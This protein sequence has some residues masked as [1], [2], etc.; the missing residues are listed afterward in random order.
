MVTLDPAWEERI[1]LGIEQTP[2]GWT[3]SLSPGEIDEICES[4]SEGTEELSRQSQS[5]IVLVSPQVR[6]RLKQLTA[7]RLPQLV[8]LSYREITRDTQIQSVAMAGQRQALA[9]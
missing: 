1:R 5:P 7:A 9:A 8:V 6:A 4:L 2:Q 3:I